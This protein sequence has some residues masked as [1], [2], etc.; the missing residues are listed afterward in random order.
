[1]A[2]QIERERK[3]HGKERGKGREGDK[4]SIMFTHLLAEVFSFFKRSF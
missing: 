2:I 1:M 4:E 3:Q